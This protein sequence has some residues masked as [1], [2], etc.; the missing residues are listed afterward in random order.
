MFSVRD[1]L[2]EFKNIFT[3]PILKNGSCEWEMYKIVPRRGSGCLTDEEYNDEDT[4]QFVLPAD[5][6]GKIEI[7]TNIDDDEISH[8]GMFD[9]EEPS[10]TKEMSNLKRKLKSNERNVELRWR[11]MYILAKS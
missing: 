1:L 2:E 5:V 11:K 7:F 3:F 9:R 6:C 8:E 4:F 10:T